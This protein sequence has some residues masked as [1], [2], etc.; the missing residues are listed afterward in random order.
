MA[1]IE[2]EEIYSR[3]FTQVEAY[4]LLDS[5][6]DMDDVRHEF[7]CNWLHAAISNPYIRKLFKHVSLDDDDEIIDYDM[8]Y[9]IDEWS[10]KE[11]V[12]EVLSYGVMYAWIEP[13]VN[14]I[15]NIVQTFGTSDEKFYSQA[16]HLSELRGLKDD[17]NRKL[18]SAVRDRGYLNNT[19]LDGSLPLRRKS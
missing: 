12:I 10:D 1:S 18:R 13:K 15:T 16:S 8:R 3:F 9:S 17:I 2:Y 7:L 14:S 6:M 11:F 4:D 5:R 19:Y